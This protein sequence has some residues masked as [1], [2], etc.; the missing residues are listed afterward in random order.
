MIVNNVRS[1]IQ[2]K[3]NKNNNV[4]TNNALNVVLTACILSS[5]SQSKQFRK[6]LGLNHVNSRHNKKY[7]FFFIKELKK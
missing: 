3:N 1:F 7:D 6:K 2:T 5:E 4:T